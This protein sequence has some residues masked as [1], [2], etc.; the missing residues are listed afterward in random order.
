MAASSFFVGRNIAV[1][2]QRFDGICIIYVNHPK[3][4]RTKDAN[5]DEDVQDAEKFNRGPFDAGKNE[6]RL[7]SSIFDS[8]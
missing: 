4:E 7:I 5:G 1:N 8:L 6:N 2:I 3:T